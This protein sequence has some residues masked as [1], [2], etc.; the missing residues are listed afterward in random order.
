LK[1]VIVI[2]WPNFNINVSLLNDADVEL[3]SAHALPKL[4]TAVV[5]PASPYQTI[6]G[7]PSVLVSPNDSIP[8]L[9]KPI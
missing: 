5:L 6:S 3:K 1:S 4:K 7:L 9:S 2:F 8:S